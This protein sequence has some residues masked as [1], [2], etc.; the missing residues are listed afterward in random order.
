MYLLIYVFIYVREKE[1]AHKLG[2]EGAGG[3][4]REKESQTD[5]VMSMEPDTGLSLRTLRS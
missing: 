4:R 3:R 1:S 2:E 5:A